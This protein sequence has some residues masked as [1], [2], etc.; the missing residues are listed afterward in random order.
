M[1]RWQNTMTFIYQ[2]GVRYTELMTARWTD[3]RTIRGRPSLV[4]R[5]RSAKMHRERIIPLTDIAQQVLQDMPRQDGVE[6]IFH[7][8]HN[9]KTLRKYR[10]KIAD[11]AGV[12]PKRSGFH[13]IRRLVGTLV[14]AASLVLGHR[15]SDVTLAYYQAADRIGTELDKLPKLHARKEVAFGY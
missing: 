12:T 8:P 9:E 15:R 3:I 14:G 1:C 2:T 6:E 13:A 10:R 4:V 11:A 7:F 5:C